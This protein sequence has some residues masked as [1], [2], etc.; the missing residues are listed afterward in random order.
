MRAVSNQAAKEALQGLASGKSRPGRPP[1]SPQSIDL[2][3]TE[4]SILTQK[5]ASLGGYLNQEEVRA[6]LE[7]PLLGHVPSLTSKQVQDF[8]RAAGASQK[9]DFEG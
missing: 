4:R 5:S 6:L 8:S 9:Q 2:R 7:S 3:E 1:Q